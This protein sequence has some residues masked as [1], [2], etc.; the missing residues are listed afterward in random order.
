MSARAILEDTAERLGWNLG[1]KYELL[2]EYV[3]RQQSDEA[4]ADFVAHQE[5]L[6]N[7]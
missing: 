5:E 3:E 1:M 4:F 7:E 6:E 2:M